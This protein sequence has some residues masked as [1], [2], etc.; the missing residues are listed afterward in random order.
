MCR[1]GTTKHDRF[2]PAQVWHG[3][4]RMSRSGIVVVAMLLS[5]C[6]PDTG[7]L[8]SGG[9]PT[10]S[11]TSEG[12]L[13]GTTS[14]QGTSSG[15][16]TTSTGAVDTTAEGGSSSGSSSGD[17][18]EEPLPPPS[19]YVDIG[20]VSVINDNDADDRD[21]TLRQD[22]REIIFASDR[23]GDQNLYRAIRSSVENDFGMLDVLG[24]S[25][26]TESDEITPELSLDG[27]LL[28][29][30]R[31]GG[32]EGFEIWYTTRPSAMSPVW[33]SPSLLAD[34]SSPDTDIAATPQDSDTLLW[35]SDRR[36]VGG[37]LDI[38]RGTFDQ[39][40]VSAMIGQ[41]VTT[42][43]SNALDCPGNS[44]D[45]MTWL[46]LESQRAGTMGDSDIWMAQRTA[47]G[48]GYWPPFN[49]TELNTEGFDGA[50]WVSEDLSTLYF[51]TDRGGS[52]DIYV[53]TKR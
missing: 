19:P 29:F 25:I 33:A 28:L 30:A 24:S 13:P 4:R 51:A 47:D 53:A 46:V 41:R 5:S 12:P 26:N 39:D 16:S 52:M 9:A 10:G 50:P 48:D 34:L 37:G 42:L 43:S 32:S 3:P 40:P 38:W 17:T 44:S 22:L 23:D 45:D 1:D 11:S 49:L 7:G 2:M 31:D 18:G 14:A 27:R 21:P 20:E 8:G 15:D 36:H 6:S 35:C